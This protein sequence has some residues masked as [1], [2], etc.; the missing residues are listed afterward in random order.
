M[1]N[2]RGKIQ[3]VHAGVERGVVI[4]AGP[5]GVA[6]AHTIA[7]LLDTIVLEARPDRA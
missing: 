4:G 6:A 5:A 3:P 2:R 7:D 1:T